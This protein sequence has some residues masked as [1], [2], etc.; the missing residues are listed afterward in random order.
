MNVWRAKINSGRAEGPD[1]W[2]EAKAYCR[3]AGVVGVGWGRPN[4]E[5]GDGA[6]L[7]EVL[8]EIARNPRWKSGAS[9]VRRLA[10]RAAVGDLVWT[11]RISC[12][13]SGEVTPPACATN[14][15]SKSPRDSISSISHSAPVS[16]TNATAA[17]SEWAPS[18]AA[19]NAAR[20]FGHRS[21]GINSPTGPESRRHQC[22]AGPPSIPSGRAPGAAVR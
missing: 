20:P 7:S 16:V 18:N 22:A 5:L 9:T 1:F 6:A 21:D 8:D 2:D 11:P 13:A 10:E 4:V 3:E 14:S 15:T 12:R 19:S 17:L